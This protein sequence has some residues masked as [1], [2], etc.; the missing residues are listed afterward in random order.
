M[1]LRLPEFG[2]RSTAPARG[3]TR[4][5]T[6]SF[7]TSNASECHEPCPAS[8]TG[9]RHNPL[10]SQALRIFA[11]T[12]CPTRIPP[13]QVSQMITQ[14][15]LDLPDAQNAQIWMATALA[16]IQPAPAQNGGSVRAVTPMADHAARSR[17]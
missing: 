16:G 7:S 2:Y 3:S 12:M 1:P 8:N 13:E 5:W 10:P 4:R 14:N 15:P 17:R 9:Q 11:P 6:R